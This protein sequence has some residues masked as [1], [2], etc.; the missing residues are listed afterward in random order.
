MKLSNQVKNLSQEHL[1]SLHATLTLAG[2]VFVTGGD[3]QE[4]FRLEKH[5]HPVGLLNRIYRKLQHSTGAEIDALLDVLT[6][7]RPPCL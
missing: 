3:Y 6:D 2:I 4:V 1:L 5:K 7:V